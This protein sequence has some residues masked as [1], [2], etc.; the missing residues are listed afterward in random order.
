MPPNT[1]PLIQPLDQGINRTVKV[2]YKTQILRQ[3]VIAIDS[4]VNPEEYKKT[5]SVLKT[6]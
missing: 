3:M 4:N 6:L 5:V 1:T 2:Y